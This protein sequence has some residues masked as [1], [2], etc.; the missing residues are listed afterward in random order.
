ML[1][2]YVNFL[3]KHLCLP[4]IFGIKTKNETFAGAQITYTAEVILPNGY[5][6]QVATSHYFGQSFTK[7][8]NL[9]F[10]TNNNLRAVPFQTS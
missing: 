6:L 10:Q 3:Q 8:F 2:L 9:E 7:L 1:K 5:C 4:V